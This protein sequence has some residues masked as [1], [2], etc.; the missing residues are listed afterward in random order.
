MTEVVHARRTGRKASL[1]HGDA[2]EQRILDVAEAILEDVGYTRLTVQQVAEAARLSRPAFYFYFDG[3][4]TL[5]AALVHRTTE[6]LIAPQRDHGEQDGAAFRRAAV[7]HTAKVWRSHGAV[8]RSMVENQA[9]NEAVHARW[10]ATVDA[11]VA[12]HAARIRED[13]PA[14]ADMAE[15]VAKA[16]I[17]MTG[18]AFYELSVSGAGVKRQRRMIETLLFITERALRPSAQE[19]G[20]AT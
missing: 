20:T 3:K 18:R 8:M 5:L 17:W 6:Q 4:A 1:R 19:D 14:I 13:E 15:D 7:K 2:R 11:S 12:L 16:L 10:A 9:S